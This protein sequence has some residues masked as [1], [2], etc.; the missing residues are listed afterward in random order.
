MQTYQAD[1]GADGASDDGERRKNER[2]L[3]EFPYGDLD[4]SINLV[5]ALYNTAGTSAEHEQLAAQL[6]LV[7]SAGGY[8]ARLSPARMFGFITVEKGRVFLTEEGEAV[9]EPLR[10]A[11]ARAEAFLKVP[12]YQALYEKFKGKPLPPPRGLENE[13]VKLGVSSKQADRARQVFE[14]SADQA[15]F[16]A[17]GKDRL[18]KPN[19]DKSSFAS[20]GAK[21]LENKDETNS[22]RGSKNETIKENNYSF[23]IPLLERI[24]SQGTSWDYKDRVKWLLAASQTF[25][26]IYTAEGDEI[27]TIKRHRETDG[28]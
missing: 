7:A 16:M 13:I 1:D 11:A 4:S 9:L 10:E 23:L 19:I 26:V 17:F 6:G 3:I 24:P 22:S 28:A 8:R 12:L 5:R 21:I 20:N 18:V 14:K 27:I 15:G 25:D 2:S